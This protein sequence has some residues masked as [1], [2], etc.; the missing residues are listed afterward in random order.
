MPSGDAN[1]LQEQVFKLLAK[2]QDPEIPVLDIV[3]MGIVRRAYFDAQHLVIEITPTYSGCPAMFEIESMITKELNAGGFEDVKVRTTF[4]EPWTSDWMTE[5][6]RQKLKQYGIA[7]PQKLVQLK[8]RSGSK[9]EQCPF[10]GSHD[11][12]LTSEFGATSCKALYFCNGC[13]QPFEYFKAI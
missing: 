6:A 2:V 13:S 9:T 12:K 4:A 8:G 10:C 5:A 7:P 11:T 3:E 1:I